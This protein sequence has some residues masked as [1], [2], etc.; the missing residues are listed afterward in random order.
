MRFI[1]ARTGAVLS[2]AALTL[3]SCVATAR[4]GDPLT[5]PYPAQDCEN[6]AEWNAPQ[7]PVR[8]YG[9]TYY[10]GPRGLTALLITSPDGHVLIDGALPNSA[11]LI[12]QNIRALGFDVRD[13]RLILNS[14][15]HFDHAG[16]VAALQRAS[17]ARVAASLSS[18]PALE[19]GSSAPG[20]PQHGELLAFPA[21][22]RVE[23]F[24]YG[25]T[26]RVGGIALTPHLTAG[27][28]P[29]GTTWT[30]R[31]CGDAG[32]LDMVYADSYNPISADGFRFSDSPAYPSALADFE[33]TFRTFE[34]L[35]CD[36]LITPH[37]TGSSLWERLAGTRELIDRQACKR[38]AAAGR[39]RLRQR[40]ETERG[41]Q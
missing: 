1:P 30:W 13:V 11:P 10:V 20:D 24:S 40:L 17:K 28:T 38:Y 19:R 26:L 9:N 33:R 6:C 25:D 18:A 37:P 41:A 27:H 29:G 23:R 21:V 12:L 32:C 31:S 2:A 7:Q 39:E 15:V 3:S 16:G 36:I 22:P 35:S 4:S 34:T 5:R 14:H 8:I